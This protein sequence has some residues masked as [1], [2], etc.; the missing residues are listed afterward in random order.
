[1]FLSIYSAR[2]RQYARACSS[3]CTTQPEAEATSELLFLRRVYRMWEGHV[4]PE[5]G[6][7]L[8]RPLEGGA[9]KTLRTGKRFAC[10]GGTI[11]VESNKLT[12]LRSEGGAA[13][14]IRPGRQTKCGLRSC[15]QT[16]EP[17]PGSL[18]GW[19]YDGQL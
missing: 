12:V 9:T 2:E 11:Q 3:T 10:A 19:F 5:S 13:P 8:Q 4:F 17:R 16:A 18:V 1:M 14:Q 15:C 6:R 7:T